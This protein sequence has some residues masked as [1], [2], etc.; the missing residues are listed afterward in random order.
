MIKDRTLRACEGCNAV[1]RG[2]I[3]C[4]FCEEPTGEAISESMMDV[5]IELVELLKDPDTRRDN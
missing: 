2:P 1:W 5:Y 4:P 3:F